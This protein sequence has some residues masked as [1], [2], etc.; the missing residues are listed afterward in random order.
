MLS[1]WL[2]DELHLQIKA[3]SEFSPT[4]L[5]AS[6]SFERVDVGECGRAA[7]SRLW[8]EVTLAVG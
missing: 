5:L 6:S 3:N 1:R 8:T 2:K 7:G 4:H